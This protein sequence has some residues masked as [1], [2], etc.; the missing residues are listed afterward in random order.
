MGHVVT[1][2][3]V[4][5]QNIEAEESVL[6]A[7][8][9]SSNALRQ[10]R[11]DSGLTAKHFYFERHA[12]IF[13]AIVRVV[14]R[15]GT[16]DELLVGDELPQHRDYLTELV[17][18]VPAAGNAK[19]YAR[20]VV[21][22]ANRRAKLEGARLIEEGAQEADEKRSA[23]LIQ[24]GLQLAA[25]DFS[26]EAQPTSS[27]EIMT[28]LL[29]WVTNPADPEVWELPWPALN[30]SLLGG[31][32]RKQMSVLAG[33]PKMGKSFI[34]DQELGAFATQGARCAIFA[35]EVSR[36]ERAVRHLTM[37]TGIASEK[38]LRKRLTDG[39]L[40]RLIDTMGRTPLPF[41][42]FEAAGWGVEKIAERIIY[43][44]Y[45]IVAVDPVTKIPGFGKEEIASAVVGRLTE[46]ASRANCH[47]ILVSHLNRS[48]GTSPGGVRPRPVVSDLRG[49]GMIEGDAHAVI[50][51]HRDQ[52]N[53]ANVLPTGELYVDRSR[54][55]PPCGLQVTQ[56]ARTLEFI[57]TS[58]AEKPPQTK[59]DTEPTT[60]H[61][62]EAG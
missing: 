51:L 25:A 7:M 20:L 33:W 10:V 1:A 43:G 61:D 21:D 17:A 31:L 28:E 45:D 18:K 5:P 22:K 49:S 19:H 11:V 57:P 26:I 37:Q 9:V 44:G 35:P 36:T 55:G 46:V 29:D 53:N 62:Q 50:F 2:S 59:L 13:S 14:D 8:L 48:R 52:D 60:K 56:V 24:E 47:V 32:R 4:P 38:I 42:Y 6:G 41:D 58:E 39:E 54:M 12:D 34:L 16:A 15:N 23:S 40:R 30:E 27:D 3:D